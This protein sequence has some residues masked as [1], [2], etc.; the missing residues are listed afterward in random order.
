MIRVPDSLT[1]NDSLEI[2]FLTSVIL[3]MV[4]EPLT[5]LLK[6]Y[7]LLKPWLYL[8]FQILK[9]IFATAF[10]AYEL[11]RFLRFGLLP[12]LPLDN[13]PAIFLMILLITASLGVALT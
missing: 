10:A 12:M 6:S 13:G 7:R 5:M 11:R 2:F 3:A 1:S 9:A 8:G 4:L